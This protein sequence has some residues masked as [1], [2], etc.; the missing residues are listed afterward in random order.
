M[1]IKRDDKKPMVI[2]TKKKAKIHIRGKR[3]T[4]M[5]GKNISVSMKMD[6]AAKWEE[7]AGCGKKRAGMDLAAGKSKEKENQASIGRKNINRDKE[8]GKG[9][10]N[11]R[12]YRCGKSR[13]YK[14]KIGSGAFQAAG[15]VGVGTALKQMDGGEEIYDSFLVMDASARP[16]KSAARFGKGLYR[17]QSLKRAKERIKQA[18]AGSRNGKGEEDKDSGDTHQTE[19]VR[20][21]KEV[22]QKKEGEVS[23]NP[24]RKNGQKETRE[25]YRKTEKDMVQKAAGNIPKRAFGKN[26]KRVQNE[27]IKNRIKKAGSSMGEAG[28]H[29][30]GALS[31]KS[32]GQ[33][34]DRKDMKFSAG[35]RMRQLFASKVRQKGKSGNSAAAWKDIAVKHTVKYLSIFCEVVFFLAVL[36]SVPVIAMRPLFTTRRLLSSFPLFLRERLH[37]KYWQVM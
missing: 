14:R 12:G 29:G 10:E 16:V 33:Q 21:E 24:E 6:N 5:K 1:E 23:C 28:K 15:T 4:K 17:R 30:T 27:D 20:K 13:E 36:L 18:E 19:E 11:N 31:G 8:S 37:R 2:H 34:T 35:N 25:A 3:K 26:I 9:R 7:I 22:L 32:A